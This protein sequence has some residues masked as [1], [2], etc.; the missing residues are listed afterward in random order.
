MY[1][2]TKF[3]KYESSR[4][5][6]LSFS[7]QLFPPALVTPTP[8]GTRATAGVEPEPQ[9]WQRQILILL[10]H[11]RTPAHSSWGWGPLMGTGRHC[12]ISHCNW[13]CDSYI[14]T[15]Q[16]LLRLWLYVQLFT[17]SSFQPWSQSSG[18]PENECG[19]HLLSL[20]YTDPVWAHFHFLDH[21][22]RV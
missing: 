21:I 18:R 11:Q 20:Q 14:Q 7:I 19:L 12:R 17:S 3:Q 16:H 4:W 6:C 8:C 15:W 10:S 1:S 13:K 22:N 2:F 5:V 9:Q